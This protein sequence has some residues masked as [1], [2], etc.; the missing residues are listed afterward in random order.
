MYNP[1]LNLGNNNGDHNLLVAGLM[2][3][4]YGD[5]ET[6]DISPPGGAAGIIPLNTV[7]YKGGTSWVNWDTVSGVQA[8]SLYFATLQPN[9]SCGGHYCAVKL[10]QEGLQ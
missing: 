10:T 7:A 3:S 4:T 9:S 6:I 8:S 5:I 1:N 2:S